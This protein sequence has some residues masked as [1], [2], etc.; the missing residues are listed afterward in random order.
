MNPHQNWFG[1]SCM[2]LR[3]K[4]NVEIHTI[5]FPTFAA[6]QGEGRRPSL[7]EPLL[8]ACLAWMLG[9]HDL[10]YLALP[11][12][13]VTTMV[14]SPPCLCDFSE[15]PILDSAQA[16]QT[17]LPGC[18]FWPSLSLSES[19]SNTLSGCYSIL[20]EPRFHHLHK[21]NNNKYFTEM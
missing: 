12:W 16:L 11:S 17:A 14:L 3:K 2:S 19:E 15:C 18:E 13:E 21:V 4:G 1:N 10:L 5:K 8:F 7:P 20:L 6:L 9:S